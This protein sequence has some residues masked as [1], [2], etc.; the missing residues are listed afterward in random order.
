MSLP[1]AKFDIIINQ[2]A[3]YKTTIMLKDA[4]GAPLDIVDWGF[5]A[6][7]RPTHADPISENVY[8]TCSVDSIPS[9]SVT[10]SLPHY[11]TKTLTQKKY[12]WDLLIGNALP[13]PD[14][15]LRLLEG[16]VTVNPG[17]TPDD[18]DLS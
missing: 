10:L 14:E 3:T 1:A 5:T 18:A 17:I 8:F 12:N 2:F 16:K 4:N 15:Y 7:L 11:V 9:A 13:D 6:S